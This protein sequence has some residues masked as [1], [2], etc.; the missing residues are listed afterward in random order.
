[1]IMQP[2]S[3]ACLTA[4]VLVASSAA[5]ADNIAQTPT[6]ATALRSELGRLLTAGKRPEAAQLIE[7]W[8]QLNPRDD[9]MYLQL[10]QLYA[11]QGDRER[12]LTTWLLMLQRM[13]GREDL[14]RTVSNRCRRLGLDEQAL[15]V[16]VNGRRRLEQEELF[17]WEL[18]Q[19]HMD[20]GRYEPAVQSM[21]DHLA[22][23]GE[24]HHQL[25][26][27]YLRSRVATLGTAA[28]ATL[29]RSMVESA[30][31]SILGGDAAG[32]SAI[33]IAKLAAGV[34]VQTGH[35]HEALSLVDMIRDLPQALSAMHELASLLEANGY[36][37]KALS[38][39]SMLLDR[40]PDS[41]PLHA[42]AQLR[43][44]EMMEA[45]GQLDMAEA[46]YL[47]IAQGRRRGPEAA[48]AFLL[49]AQLQFNGG[50]DPQTAQDPPSAAPSAVRSAAQ[51]AAV[52]LDQLF[53]QHEQGSWL[54]PALTLRAE[55]A[56]RLDDLDTSEIYLQKRL[57]QA[58]GDATAR[59]DVA[60][61]AFYRANFTDAATLLD[62]LVRADPGSRAANDALQLL[63]LIE[64]HQ[65]EREGLSMLAG[66]LLLERQLQRKEAN[67]AW[68]WLRT[69]ASVE[70][71]ERSLLLRAQLREEDDPG[72]ALSLYETVL[73]SFPGGHL[74]LPAHLGRG[75]MLELTG[76]VPEALKA[77]E[78]ALLQ[79]PEDP[80]TPRLRLDIQR[81]RRT[82]RP[83]PDKGERG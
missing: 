40:Y 70:L 29:V 79:F 72:E 7:D 11:D 14:Y 8:L 45:R 51:S 38:V 65:S 56:L 74:L 31:N 60:Q 68:E 71:G 3:F 43:Q 49:A 53:T 61:L 18:A 82:L 80:A 39:Y 2:L 50:N 13:P 81:L 12:A 22:V 26:A 76:H 1:M 69:D 47:S 77:Y 55:C 83:T 16:L 73:A 30:R 5:A 36:E 64:S 62:S 59:F 46:A 34:A 4:A 20:A 57:A 9:R 27:G 35:P 32:G 23:K 25:V 41:H 24:G 54:L 28:S 42:H 67:S 17:T 58:P 10:G 19:I 15:T 48:Q 66:A 44:A 6:D 37:E 78:T 52:T 33:A 21:F 75:R 63:L